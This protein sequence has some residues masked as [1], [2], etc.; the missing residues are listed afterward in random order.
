M[1]PDQAWQ[2]TLGQLEMEMPKAAYDTWVRETEMLAYEDG[3]FMI[4]VHNAYPQAIGYR[5]A[6]P[7]KSPACSPVSW[8]ARLKCASLSGKIRLI[9]G[10]SS[11]R[12]PQ[13]IQKQQI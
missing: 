8:T 4:G 13:P 10:Q 5:A 2:A 3:S 12:L 7:V 6:C 9:S 1:R 11:I